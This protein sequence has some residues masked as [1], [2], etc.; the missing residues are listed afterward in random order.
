MKCWVRIN[1][2]VEKPGSIRVWLLL[3][4]KLSAIRIL[5]EGPLWIR[6]VAFW[7]GVAAYCG[8]KEFADR[9][10][11]NSIGT[12]FILNAFDKYDGKND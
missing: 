7:G 10:F 9:L 12:F 6:K 5:L 2:N 11:R 3:L 1:N 4:K 8:S